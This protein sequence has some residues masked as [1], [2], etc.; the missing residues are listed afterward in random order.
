MAGLEFYMYEDELWC[1]SDDGKNFIVDEGCTEVVSY[2]LNNVRMKYP[3]AYKD[4]EKCY[5]RS[6]QNV[7]WYQF[8]MAR[9][10]CKCNFANLDATERDVESISSSGAFRFEKVQ[11]PLRGE[12][13]YEGRIC[14]PK[15]DST[16]S[17]QELRVMKLWY[18]GMDNEEI[19]DELYISPG[20]VKLHV[21]SAY[22]K[23]GVHTKAEFVK[24][25]KEHKLF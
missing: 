25:A 2:I 13:P 9:R 7:S 21:K 3:E 24:Y 18:D 22:Q 19:G 11:C 6:A 17:R 12:C 20:T 4:L 5:H 10:F 16:L 15:Y 23:L 1:K 8:L 14:M